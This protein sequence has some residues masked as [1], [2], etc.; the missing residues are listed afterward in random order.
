MQDIYELSVRKDQYKALL[1]RL[2]VLKK[3]INTSEQNLQN[4]LAIEDYFSIDG[5][6]ADSGKIKEIEKKI[7][8]INIK[9]ENT[10]IPSVENKLTNLASKITKLENNSQGV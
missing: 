8:D 1:E 5:E 2:R 9:L 10:I 6:S 4:A 7:S 3:Q